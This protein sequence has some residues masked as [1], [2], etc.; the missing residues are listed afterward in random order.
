MIRGGST[1]LNELYWHRPALVR[2]VE[3]MG[4][5][6]VVGQTL[7]D[8]GDAAMFA[9]QQAELERLARDERVRG[10]VTLAAAPHSIYTVPFGVLRRVADIAAEHDLLV[11]IHLSE[12]AGEVEHCVAAHGCRPAEL[13]ARAGL[14]NERL[15]AV[16]GQFLDEAELHLLGAAGAA[17]VT[18]PA[19]NLKLA[20]A[21]IVPYGA[22]RR[23]GVR[24][25]LGTDG[26]ASNNTLSMIES[27]KLAALLQKHQDADATALPARDAL[28]MATSAAAAV[29]GPA[30]GGAS[31]TN[32]GA[33]GTSLNAVPA[34]ALVMAGAAADIVL[35][36]FSDAATQPVHDPV[37]TL[38]YAASAAHVHTTIC[39]GR[40][41]MHD[42]VV[43]V[44]DEAEVIAAAR[45]S[46]ASV[47]EGA[48]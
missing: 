37:S 48:A 41:L 25:C 42:R 26:A 39:D 29:F 44:C 30:A 33:A 10:R 43:E 5:R 32:S 15:V 18:N 9:R 6:A 17:L 47:T 23:A 31:A 38:V 46:A 1:F 21:G 4:V 7:I 19:A 34:H 45:R 13:L 11:H 14:I 28:T 8:L 20:T 36:D 2:A 27:M 12:T 22:A 3:D 40:V 16:H 24:M 35:L